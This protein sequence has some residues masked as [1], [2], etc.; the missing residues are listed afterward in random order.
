MSVAL[1]ATPLVGILLSA[2]TLGETVGPSL[3]AGAVL[4]A[5]GIRLVVSR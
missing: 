2:F 1:L 5:T 4:V 3:I